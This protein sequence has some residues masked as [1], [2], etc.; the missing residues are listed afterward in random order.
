M[1]KQPSYNELFKQNN[2]LKKKIRELESKRNREVST[3]V[4]V[5]CDQYTEAM[6][7]NRISE[8]RAEKIK[9]EVLEAIKK[10]GE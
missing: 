3:A 9:F 4:F 2:I 7:N 8:S 5:T 10:A 1:S 6:R